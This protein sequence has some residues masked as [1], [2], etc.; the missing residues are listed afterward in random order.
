MSNSVAAQQD[1]CEDG[2]RADTGPIL[3]SVP[4]GRS[5]GALS[6][7]ND[8]V[9]ELTGMSITVHL[10]S[11]SSQNIMIENRTDR[12]RHVIKRRRRLVAYDVFSLARYIR[13][14]NIRIV[15]SHLTTC[16]LAA[17]TAK[18]AKVPSLRTLHGRLDRPGML[19]LRARISFLISIYLLGQ[20][21]VAVSD[22]VGLDLQ[23]HYGLRKGINLF[24][25]P[26]G[27]RLPARMVRTALSPHDQLNFV[28]VGRFEDWKGFPELILA[29]QR[30][31]ETNPS[32]RLYCIGDGERKAM[33][34]PSLIASGAIVV[35]EGWIPR[36]QVIEV[37][38][39]S[40]VFVLPSYSEGLSISLL[41]AMSMGLVPL[42]SEAA[43]SN[44]LVVHNVNGLVFKT[45]SEDDLFMQMHRLASDRVSL[46]RYQQA[47]VDTI[48]TSFHIS[49]TVQ[50]HIEL[51]DALVSNNKWVLR[52]AE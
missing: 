40:H 28:F 7:V 14:E 3:M 9:E 2:A 23:R 1:P 29:F 48:V 19:S 12:S 21:V 4:S 43:T 51:Y 45:K 18:L 26:N 15:H 50:Q 37:L 30:L 38:Q 32:I 11:I 42:V 49:R 31:H 47:A 13:D 41:E 34:D 52:T 27:F 35:S 39:K 6:V 44:D 36:Q 20:K 5:G 16:F 10:A 24:V 33:I 25:I 22:K 46:K 17:L 8:I